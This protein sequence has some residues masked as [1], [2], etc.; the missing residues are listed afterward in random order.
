MLLF[1]L[2]ILVLAIT[3]PSRWTW[4]VP[5]I[6]FLVLVATQLL[7][8]ELMPLH[9]IGRDTALLQFL[10]VAGLFSLRAVFDNWRSK[11]KAKIEI[12]TF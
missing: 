4:L 1:L 6:S 7:P 11:R 5:M 3:L 9:L 10:F 8:A 12:D 2:A